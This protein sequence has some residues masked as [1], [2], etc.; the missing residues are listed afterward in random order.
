MS[1]QLS[2]AQQ[3]YCDGWGCS[4]LVGPALQEA[5]GGED[6][7]FISDAGGG[8]MGVADGVGGWQESGINPAGAC[9]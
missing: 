2:E 9:H 4:G 5:Y 6:A 1:I 3:S 8:A 7:F